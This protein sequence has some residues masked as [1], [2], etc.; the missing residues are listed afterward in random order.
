MKKGLTH[1]EVVISFVMFILF[2]VLILSLMKPLRKTEDKSYLIGN[3]ER[4]VKEKTTVDVIRITIAIENETFN[5][6]EQ[7]SN[8]ICIE[9]NLTEF[10]I[11]TTNK[12]IRVEADNSPV[13]ASISDGLATINFGNAKL[14]EIYLSEN[15][16]EIPPSCQITLDMSQFSYL[17]NF[18]IGLITE[19]SMLSR[20]K[21]EALKQEYETNYSKLKE[22]FSIR[23]DFNILFVNTTKHEIARMER[24]APSTINIF[25]KEFPVEIIDKEARIQSGIMKI[26]VW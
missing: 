4:M 10:G 22:E 16:S 5:E 25:A 1:V 21:L 23:G 7:M 26:R 9:I 3:V 13:N 14:Y 19:V 17:S 6:L 18:T 2:L 8:G 11:N 12:K 20:E 24:N 15:L